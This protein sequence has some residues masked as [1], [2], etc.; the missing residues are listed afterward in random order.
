MRRKKAILWFQ[1]DLRIHDNEALLDA[2]QFAEELIPVYVFDEREINGSTDILKECKTGRFRRQFLVDSVRDLR[3]SLQKMGTDLV[4]REGKSEEILFSL[5]KEFDADAVYCNRE[6]TREEVYR[7]ETLEKLL[8]SIGREIRY[9]RGKMLYHTADLPFPITHAPD[10]F[11][12]FKKEVERFVAIRKPLAV[13]EIPS[14]SRKSIFELGDLPDFGE[15]VVTIVKGGETV[16]LKNLETLLSSSSAK[17]EDS[18]FM[19]KQIEKLMIFLSDGCLSPK[20]L[21]HKLSEWKE[22]GGNAAIL[23]YC[24]TA[25]LWRDF[26]RLMGKKYRSLIFE[27]GGVKEKENKDASQDITIFNIWKEGRTGIPYVDAC[28]KKLKS[29]GYLSNHEKKLVSS[30]LIYY[31]KVD[32]RLGAEYF[33]NLLINYDP[34]SVWGHWNYIAGISS[35]NKDGVVV[36]CYR[37]A[38]KYD[39]EGDLVRE[40]IPSLNILPKKYIH[41]PFL[42]SEEEQLEFQIKLGASYP[43]PVISPGK[44][45]G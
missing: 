9:S 4:I 40:W 16:A 14:F 32:W 42:L 39:P 12:Q 5:A 37:E 24:F 43:M 25:L 1:K 31:L 28:M 29:T 38:Q 11:Q 23:D 27:P 34:C 35:D 26:Y 36:N 10:C 2:S 6:R 44:I 17:G 20:Y 7:Q 13:E 15:E 18:K 21:F 3:N 45:M 41:K 19:K 22:N 8:W 33:E 30:F